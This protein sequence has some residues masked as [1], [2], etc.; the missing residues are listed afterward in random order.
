ML[1][2]CIISANMKKLFSLTAVMS[3]LTGVCIKFINHRHE[4][5]SD[6]ILYLLSC[7]NLA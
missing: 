4:G 1:P 2:R 5:I 3:E 6:I 7:D